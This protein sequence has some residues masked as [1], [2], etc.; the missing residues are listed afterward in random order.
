MIDLKTTKFLR[1]ALIDWL[2]VFV[3]ILGLATFWY[4]YL[5]YLD[6][7]DCFSWCRKNAMVF[8]VANYSGLPDIKF[9]ISD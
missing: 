2:L 7:L 5:A 1:I 4:E 3:I 6:K 8:C 9:N